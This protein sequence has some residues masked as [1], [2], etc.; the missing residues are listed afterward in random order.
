[1]SAK[2]TH[3]VYSSNLTTGPLT[4]VLARIDAESMHTDFID[5]EPT[6]GQDHNS[7]IIPENI[8]PKVKNVDA[9]DYYLY[10][11]KTVADDGKV[12]ANLSIHRGKTGESVGESSFTLVDYSKKAL[13]RITPQSPTKPIEQ[14]FKEASLMEKDCRQFLE[15]K[16]RP[17]MTTPAKFT[18]KF[19]EFFDQGFAVEL[20][21]LYPAD[22]TI[23]S[24]VS[25]DKNPKKPS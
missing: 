17:F 7:I 9:G 1:M 5:A 2:I 15:S 12:S 18:T 22:T 10:I 24:S 19:R 21:E 8:R 4:Q 25:R 20:Q 13:T 3:V 16:L 14:D 6:A 23:T 11:D